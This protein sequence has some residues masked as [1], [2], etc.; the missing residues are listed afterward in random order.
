LPAWVSRFA[1]TATTNKNKV[2]S[3]VK[4]VSSF[5]QRVD[6][7]FRKAV[8]VLLLISGVTLVF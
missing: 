8:L 3:A 5:R 2:A 1:D 6:A 7:T 4:N